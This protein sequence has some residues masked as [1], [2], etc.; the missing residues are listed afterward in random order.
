[1]RNGNGDKLEENKEMLNCAQTKSIPINKKCLQ[2]KLCIWF[3]SYEN[4]NNML[5]KEA[6]EV[7]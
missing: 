6:G 4:D 3:Y 2:W 1:M 7:L 5:S